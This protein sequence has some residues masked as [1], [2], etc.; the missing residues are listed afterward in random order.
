MEVQQGLV[1]ILLQLQGAL[2]GLQP[3]APLITVGFLRRGKRSIIA[4]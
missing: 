3:A 4:D 2:Q 1:D